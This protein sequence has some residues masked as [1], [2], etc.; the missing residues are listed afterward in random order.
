MSSLFGMKE[1]SAADSKYSMQRYSL[2]PDDD[3]AYKGEFI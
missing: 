2:P 1:Q 3:E